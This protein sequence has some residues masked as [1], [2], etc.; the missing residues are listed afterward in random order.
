M[1]LGFRILLICGKLFFLVLVAIILYQADLKAEIPVGEKGFNDT[2]LDEPILLPG[3]FKLSFLGIKED[4]RE[5]KADG[6]K[7]VILYYGQQRCPYCKALI[8][9]SFNKKDIELYIKENF[10]I[11]AID[12]RGSRIVTTLK[13][14]KITEKKYS[15]LQNASFTPT[16]EFYDTQGVRVH[17]LVGYFPPYTIRAALEFVSDEHYKNETFKTYLDRG[18][19]PHRDSK[20]EIYYRHFSMKSPYYLARNKIRAQRPLMVIFE[21]KNCHACDVLHASVFQNEVILSRINNIDVVQLDMSADEKV[22]DPAGRKIT[23]RHWA[24]ELGIFYAPTMVFYDESGVELLR[25]GSVVHF[26][27]LNKVLR[28]IDTHAYRNYKNF[29]DWLVAN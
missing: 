14:E 12:V 7:G 3:W 21:Q 9:N 20:G 8:E 23:S 27:R 5:A 6:K 4:L 17:R 2:V 19:I 22:I 1:F 25:L 28:Y 10:D 11:I 26:N 29:I 13:D 16:L 15:I 24:E 18:N